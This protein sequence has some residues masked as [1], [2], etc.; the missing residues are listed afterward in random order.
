MSP[1]TPDASSGLEKITQRELDDIIKKHTTFLKGIRG[2]ARAVLKF[3]DLSHLDFRGCNLSQ[4]DFH[5][6]SC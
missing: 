1:S 3:K 6:L 2:G 5:R 4:G